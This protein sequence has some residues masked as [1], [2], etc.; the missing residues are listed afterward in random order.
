MMAVYFND[1]H[2]KEIDIKKIKNSDCGIQFRIDKGH[3]YLY[4]NGLYGEDIKSGNHLNKLVQFVAAHSYVDINDY[5]L[6]IEINDKVVFD[7]YN[8]EGR[9]RVI[10][11]INI[12]KMMI[13]PTI[14]RVE[15]KLKLSDNVTIDFYK[16]LHRG[17]VLI[18]IADLEKEGTFVKIYMEKR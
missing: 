4:M 12:F 10:A 14:K 11:K 1:M 8:E 9:Q 13:S 18:S 15:Y 5:K 17:T 2:V 7:T 3:K 6:K 16:D